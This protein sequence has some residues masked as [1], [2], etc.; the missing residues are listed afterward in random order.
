M[1][2]DDILSHVDHRPWNLPKTPWKIYQEWNS[3]IFMHWKVDK[4]M[5]SKFI[6]K[7]LEIDLFNGVAW[8]SIVAFSMENIRPKFF[9]AISQ[10]SNFDEVNVRTYVK[11]D[12]VHFWKVHN[13]SLR[14][15]LFISGSSGRT[16]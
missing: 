3:A 4:E 8:I 10:V 9:P 1:N 6:P 2:I 12:G 7:N 14:Y 15:S 5:L 16:A 13:L 11:H